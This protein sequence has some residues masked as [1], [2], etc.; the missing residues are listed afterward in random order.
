MHRSSEPDDYIC[1][2]SW[3]ADGQHLAVGLS[4]AET[5]IWDAS[6]QKQVRRNAFIGIHSI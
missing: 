1:S 6:R 5:Q 3:A 4:N 2:V